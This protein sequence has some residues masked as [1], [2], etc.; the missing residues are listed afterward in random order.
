MVRKYT[1]VVE[2]CLPC[3]VSN[4]IIILILAMLPHPTLVGHPYLLD[5]RNW[6]INSFKSS[7]YTKA[8]KLLNPY[9]NYLHTTPLKPIYLTRHIST[10]WAPFHYL[11]SQEVLSKDLFSVYPFSTESRRLCYSQVSTT[12]FSLCF[13]QASWSSLW[14]NPLVFHTIFGLGIELCTPGVRN[15]KT[16]AM[17]TSPLKTHVLFYF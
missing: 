9:P 5:I 15:F 13:V 7:S 3:L 1:Q 2:A 8:P 11:N 4:S 17:P 16:V 10:F 14:V 12:S 6:L